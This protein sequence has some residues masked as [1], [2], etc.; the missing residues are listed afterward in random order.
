MKVIKF[1]KPLSE[2]WDDFIISCPMAT[3][4]HSRKFLS[5]H[6]DRFKDE[7]VILCDEDGNWMGV[8]P[9]AL[10]PNDNLKIISHPGSTYGGLLHQGK[11]LGS[12]SIEALKL[13]ADY[14]KKSG[15]SHLIYKAIPKFYHKVP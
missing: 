1:E 15:Y 5:Y 14:Y 6:G 11:L 3:F 12:A 10:D 2:Q 8:F 4:L 13:I 9:A 7:S